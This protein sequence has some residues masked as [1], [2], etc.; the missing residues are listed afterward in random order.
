MHHQRDAAILLK[1]NG[2]MTLLE[3]ECLFY[4]L[5]SVDALVTL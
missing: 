2:R 3:S 4:N 1:Q 5:K